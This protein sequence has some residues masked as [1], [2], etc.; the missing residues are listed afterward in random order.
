MKGFPHV[1]RDPGSLRC[2]VVVVV[3]FAKDPLTIR[4][5]D[6][7]FRIT[8]PLLFPL[9]PPRRAFFASIKLYTRATTIRT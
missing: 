9:F 4:A 3:L 7:M 5:G 1:A 8:S 2:V 6:E